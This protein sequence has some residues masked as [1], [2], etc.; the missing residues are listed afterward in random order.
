M[1]RVKQRVNCI[2]LSYLSKGIWIDSCVIYIVGS[3]LC[4][5]TVRHLSGINALALIIINEI[6]LINSYSKGQ[7]AFSHGFY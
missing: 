6:F 7:L 2:H 3:A 4:C 1:Y 5:F